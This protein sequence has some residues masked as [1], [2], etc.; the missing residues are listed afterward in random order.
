MTGQE[1]RYKRVL[2]RHI[3]QVLEAGRKK[4]KPFLLENDP[5][6]ILGQFLLAVERD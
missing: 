4:I 5:E 3:E 1:I 6:T 2:L